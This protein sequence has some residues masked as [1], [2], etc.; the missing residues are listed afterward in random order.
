M[1]MVG[2]VS[3]PNIIGDSTPAPLSSTVVQGM[4]RDSL[5][6]TGIVVP[7]RFPWAPSPTT[8][9]GR[10]AVAALK[11]GCDIRSCPSVSTRPTKECSTPC[12]QAS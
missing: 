11:A 1:I 5:G 8:T 2:H 10:A 9:P 3:L 12:R 7:T 4:L 6:Y